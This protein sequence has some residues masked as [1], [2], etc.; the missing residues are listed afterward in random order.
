MKSKTRSESNA[1]SGANALEN[2]LKAEETR[3]RLIKWLLPALVVSL[4]LNT[5]LAGIGIALLA[6]GVQD[7]Y[8]VMPPYKADAEPMVALRGDPLTYER[9]AMWSNEVVNRLFDF[10]H[11]NITRHFRKMNIF[12]TPRGFARFRA[13]L[14]ANNW[15]LELDQRNAVLYGSVSELLRVTLVGPNFWEL[16]GKVV[17]SMEAPG[18]KPTSDE[19]NITVRLQRGDRA[20]PVIAPEDPFPPTNNLGLRI[21]YVELL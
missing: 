4:L 20:T 2:Y 18:Y 8:W 6:R 13:D 10:P 3:R 16:K 9:V 15:L 5:V 21:E 11:S 17:I 1:P 14:D 19:K 7:R 12:F